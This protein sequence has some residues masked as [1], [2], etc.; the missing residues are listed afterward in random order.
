MPDRRIRRLPRDRASRAQV[1]F[2]RRRVS[3]V[4]V[5]RAPSFLSI[6]S[7]ANGQ[8]GPIHVYGLL[9]AVAVVVAG[10]I[11]KRR[12]DGDSALVEEVA[13]W[14]FP[15][16]LVGGRLYHLITSWNEVPN[17]WWGPLA[18]WKG[19]LGIW[20]GIALGVAVGHWRVKRAGPSVL[21]FMDAG[22]TSL[23]AAHA[24]IR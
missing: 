11:T 10:I 5:N 3:L 16:G 18:V 19:G 22:A 15:A 7:P 13:L 2:R 20:G 1:N 6:P 14:G 23:L 24:V 12:W 17:T 8:I 9:F 21:S 4:P